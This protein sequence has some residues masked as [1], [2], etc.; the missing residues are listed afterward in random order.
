VNTIASKDG[1]EIYFKDWGKAFPFYGANRA[2]AKVS[3]GILDP[4]LLWSMQSRLKNTYESVKAFSETDFTEDLKNS[5]FQL[6]CF[7][8]KTIRSCQCRT[9]QGSQ[10]DSSKVRRKSTIP[11]HRAACPP[12]IRIR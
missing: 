7:M 12:H 9:P 11:A 3:Q 1:T 4:F 6:S 2:G 10:Q 5:T 8:A